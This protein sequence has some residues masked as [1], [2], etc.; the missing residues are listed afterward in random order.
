MPL[1]DTAVVGQAIIA[2]SNF[3]D[4]FRDDFN[5][6]SVE[7][8]SEPG[9]RT[10]DWKRG[11]IHANMAEF[12]FTYGSDENTGNGDNFVHAAIN[13]ENSVYPDTRK[14]NTFGPS[15]LSVNNSVLTITSRP[16]I[17]AENDYARV[18][19][20]QL[21]HDGSLGAFERDHQVTYLSEMLSKYGR[22]AMSF[23]RLRA[24][25]KT[26]Y[27][28]DGASSDVE[29]RKA[30]FPAALWTLQDIPYGCDINGE[31][32]GDGRTTYRP[33]RPNGGGILFEI[34]ADEN[35]G[36]SA[37]KIH[38]TVHTHPA[39]T[40]QGAS[41]SYPKTIDIGKDLRSEWRETGVDVFPEK[42][43]FFTD[44]IY[45]HE[46]A[47][48]D[49]IRNGL[50]LYVPQSGA[51]YDPVMVN[52][53]TA[54]TNGRQTHPDGSTRYMCHV[55][56]INLARDGKYPRDLARQ[57]LDGGGTLPAHQDTVSMEVDYVEMRPLIVEN[58]D[59]LPMRINGVAMAAD[60]STGGTQ[61]SATSL[62]QQSETY[63]DVQPE[64]V[65]G[66]SFRVTVKL[67]PNDDGT[68]ANP[69]DYTFTWSVDSTLQVVGLDTGPE[70][71]AEFTQEINVASVARLFSCDVVKL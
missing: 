24:K 33:A 5:T 37:T 69:D 48:P 58:P 31:P 32:F 47:A 11:F 71:V 7:T 52:T 35:F 61:T 20:Y 49:E 57:V 51:E 21:N 41:T 6:L 59:T 16:K 26:P 25:V 39:G 50:P 42:I 63:I 29:Q 43:I 45:T 40:A 55:P 66:N 56:I 44:G 34:D 9:N 64:G 68:P 36:E 53:T 67:K 30:I 23:F 62:I 15:G 70:I 10:G 12:G 13:F 3:G 22:V 65:L 1:S 17:T 2:E 46:V 8:S 38:Q 27:G 18:K 14:P 19:D 60:G 28:A 4:G 54:Q